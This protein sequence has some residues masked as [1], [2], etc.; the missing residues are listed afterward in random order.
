MESAAKLRATDAIHS[1][2]QLQPN[3]ARLVLDYENKDTEMRDVESISVG[4]LIKILAGETIPLDGVLVDCKAS[5]DESTMTG[6]AYPVRKSDGDEVL[7]GTI[8]LDGTVIVKTTKPSN[9][10]LINNVIDLVEQ[11]Q[12]GKA[13][14]QRLV[15]KVSSIFVPLVVV[16][17]I[18]SSVFWAFFAGSIIDNP[19]NSNHELAIMV[20]V[21]SLVIA[22]P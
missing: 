12:M 8:V 20:L 18:L 16:L 3:N 2:M 13:P 7:A 10:C 11:A 15:D 4:S 22:C 1:L 21:S 9:D 19:M 5:I 6:E 17:A 14:I